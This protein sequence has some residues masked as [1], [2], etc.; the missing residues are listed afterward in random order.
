MEPVPFNATAYEFEKSLQADQVLDFVSKNKMLSIWSSVAYVIVVFGGRWVMERKEK[1][2]LN[3][4]LALWSGTLAIFSVMGTLRMWPEIIHVL[5][6]EGLYSSACHLGYMQHPVTKFWTCLFVLSKV[7]EL[8]DTVFIVLR[9]QPLI[10]LHWYHHITVLL[11]AWYSYREQTGSGRWFICM[12]F[13]VH[14][15]MYTY[16]ALRALKFRV[17][18]QVRMVITLLQLIQMIVGCALNFYVYSLKNQGRHCNITYENIYYSFV[19]YFS[20]FVLFA[21]FFYDSYINPAP[22]GSNLRQSKTSKSD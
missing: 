12:N 19:M 18:N 9:K 14:A 7:I 5:Q 21:K 1:F 4:A 10:F 13:A 2:G 15:V 11:Y 17:P 16:Y 22:R 3:S 20:Y 8:G 6:Y